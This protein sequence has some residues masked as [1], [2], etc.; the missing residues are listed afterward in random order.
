M[1]KPFLTATI[2]FLSFFSFAQKKN[3]KIEYHIHRASAPIKIDGIVDEKAWTD[4][5]LATDFY[6]VLPMDT[7]YAKVRTDVKMSYDDKNLYVVFINYDKLPGPYIVESLKRDFAFGKNDNDLLFL[8][9]FD[10][11]TNGFS[12]GASAMGAQWD[13]LMSNGAAIT[14][15]WDNKWVSEV[16]Y[17]DDKWVWECAIP[18]K[19]LRYKKG[20]TR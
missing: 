9:T 12:F 15:T 6:Q 10:D 2:L 13:G 17:D 11:Q 18:F 19:T 1:L 7:S 5:Q 16:K 4:A 20:I 14:T 3:D 8:D